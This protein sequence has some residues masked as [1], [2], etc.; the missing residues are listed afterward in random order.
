MPDDSSPALVVVAAGGLGTRVHG[1]AQFIP[2]EFYPVGGR[3]GITRLLEEIAGAG[4]ARVVIVY[5]PYYEQFA[6]WARQVLSPCDHSRYASAAGTE[7]PAA[8]PAGLTVS[9]IPQDGPYGDLT[10]VLNGA[11]HLAARDGLHVAFADNLYPGTSPLRLLRSACGGDVAV[12]ASR[13]RPALAPSRGILITS[14]G[15]RGEPR[16]VRALVEKPDPAQARAM[17]QEHGTG[18]LLMLEGRA[19]LSSPFIQFARGRQQ[20]MLGTEPRLALAIGAYARA[21]PVVAVLADGDVIDLGAPEVPAPREA[22]PGASIR[23][24]QATPASAGARSGR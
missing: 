2:K 19:W 1:W 6:A 4:P 12:L 21:H 3:P 10:S 11:D 17:E 16:H 8:V 24:S 22:L 23:R 18:S 9:L 15:T 7:V 20:A 13:Y 5:H 14:P